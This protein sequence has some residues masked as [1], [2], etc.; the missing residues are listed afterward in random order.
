[1]SGKFT[2]FQTIKIAIAMQF[3]EQLDT[4][5]PDILAEAENLED[6]VDALEN[7]EPQEEEDMEDATKDESSEEEMDAEEEEAE[8]KED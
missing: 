8:E 7:E 3:E 4:P 2:Y 5:D 1:M 6:A